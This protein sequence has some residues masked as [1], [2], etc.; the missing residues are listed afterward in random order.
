MI[1]G[2]IAEYEKLLYL[3][4]TDYFKNLDDFKKDEYIK[5][6]VR[7]K[8]KFL[9]DDFDVLMQLHRTTYKDKS[10]L[11]IYIEDLKKDIIYY[12]ENGILQ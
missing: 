10:L 6:T 8:L 12:K 3:S 7:K 5:N 4:L 9:I 1:K 11:E 2:S